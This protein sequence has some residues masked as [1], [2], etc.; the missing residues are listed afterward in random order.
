MALTQDSEAPDPV[1]GLAG[2]PRRTAFGGVADTLR[3]AREEHDQ[4]LATIAQVLRIRYSYLE[5]I[6]AGEFERLPGVA[7]ATG[8]LR[9]YAEFLGLDGEEIVERFKHESR[10]SERKPELVFPEPVTDV[11][12]PGGAIVL[13]SAVLLALAYGGWLYLSNEGKSVADLIAPL[14]ERMQ[15]MIV[16]ERGGVPEPAPVE[17]STGL[18]P[19]SPSAA[20]TPEG[21]SPTDGVALTDG[22]VVP[23]PEQGATLQPERDQPA[24]GLPEPPASAAPLASEVAATTARADPK[25]D[26][27]AS[28]TQ[29]PAEPAEVETRSAR[30]EAA[31]LVATP[32]QSEPAAASAPETAPASTS[33]RAASVAPPPEAPSQPGTGTP[34]ASAST[35]ADPSASAST[36]ADPSA[37]SPTSAD[38]SATGS[39]YGEDTV[40]IPAPP[41]I[42]QAMAMPGS[43]SPRVYGESNENAR[44]VLRAV[45]DSWVQVRDRQDALLLTR[46]LRVGDT[47][48]VPDRQGLTL[49][50]GNA[51]GL[52]IE[53]DGVKIPPLGPVG[54]VRRQIVLDPARLLDGTAAPR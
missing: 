16:G 47:Y 43:R 2:G 15:A 9:T 31:P 19:P 45:Q 46:V 29:A 10:G 13:I 23:A 37:T 24:G 14:P 11:R 25:P 3:R 54:S 38:P 40:V 1:A 28:D 42:P 26:A 51:G 8:F 34:S 48:H 52:E 49:L 39:S 5:A 21:G 4:D 20:P 36:S 33:W 18:T 7:Y 12:I 22:A 6:E 53:V 41:S 27:P 32:A 35:S 17:R 44:I 30:A 50:T